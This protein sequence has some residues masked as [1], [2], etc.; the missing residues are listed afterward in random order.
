MSRGSVIKYKKGRDACSNFDSGGKNMQK[1]TLTI[2][3]I[4]EILDVP[5]ATLRF[6]EEK[7]LFH[8]AKG[9]NSYRSYTTTDLIH[10]ADIL[11]YRKMGI[12]VKDVGNFTSVSLSEQGEALK[13]IQEQLME[14]VRKYEQMYQ[15]LCQHQQR[16]YALLQLMVNPFVLEDIPFSYVVSWDFREKSR[17]LEYVEDPSCYVWYRDTNRQGHGQ[18]GLITPAPPKEGEG[19][20]L[21]HRTPGVKYLTFPVKAVVDRDYEGLEA[22]D[23]VSRIQ[24]RYHT[25][26]FMARYLLSCKEGGQTVEYLKG[27]LELPGFTGGSV[28]I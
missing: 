13:S 10:I 7:G 22:F 6:W 21:W 3:E 23:T 17:M 16:Y 2:G 11:F 8:V 27:Y 20:L 5:A 26:C 14:K 25:G 4:S 9:S 18:K 1:K 12:P 15:R 28:E 19:S 24:S